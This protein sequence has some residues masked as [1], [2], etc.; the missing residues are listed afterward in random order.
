[1]ESKDVMA[2]PQP[3]LTPKPDIVRRRALYFLLLSAKTIPSMFI[4]FTLLFQAD[5]FS[6]FHSFIH[7]YKYTRVGQSEYAEDH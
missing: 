4:S 2:A 1:M 6:L 3:E 5:C 7:S